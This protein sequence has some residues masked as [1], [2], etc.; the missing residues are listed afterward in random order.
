MRRI[1]RVCALAAAVMLAGC[2]SQSFTTET[3]PEYMILRD[4]TPLYRY[5]PAQPGPP[6]ARLGR[7]NRVRLLR[8]EFGYSL[9]QVGELQ[10]GYVANEDMAPA[11]PGRAVIEID[12][13]SLGDRA[14]AG[15]QAPYFGPLH[16]DVPLPMPDPN[17]EAAPLDSPPSAPAADAPEPQIEDIP[18]TTPTPTP[19]PAP[20]PSPAG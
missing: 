4:R 15:G 18:L 1:Q 19:S 16:D 11:P 17:L 8:R 9:V 3:A 5:G 13:Q 20:G 6:D 2:A 7:D 14:D 10:T 12:A